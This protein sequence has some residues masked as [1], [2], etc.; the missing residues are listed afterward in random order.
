MS[1]GG[2]F[3]QTPNQPLKGYSVL[4]RWTP[5]PPEPGLVGHC[6]PPSES[7]LPEKSGGLGGLGMLFDFWVLLLLKMLIGAYVGDRF[8]KRCLVVAHG[9]YRFIGSDDDV[10][11][12]MVECRFLNM[13]PHFCSHDYWKL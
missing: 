10:V 7:A 1:G 5:P 4:L 3:L 11:A 2:L 8:C 9:V 12:R 13:Q 6:K